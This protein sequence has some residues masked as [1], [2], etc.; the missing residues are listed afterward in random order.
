VIDRSLSPPKRPRL[1]GYDYSHPGAYFVTLC[2]HEKAHLFGDIV[3]GE[4]RLNR[5]GEIVRIEW[6]RSPELRPELEFGVFVIMPNHVH[7]IVH[8]RPTVENDEMTRFLAM[9]DSGLGIEE[10][11]CRAQLPARYRACAGRKPRSLGSF[12]AGFKA[13]STKRI[14][15]L[16]GTTGVR[17][18]QPDYFES[19]LFS[20]RARLNAQNYILENVS[21]WEFDKEN[22]LRSL[23]RT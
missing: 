14:N 11:H 4:M 15:E 9:R 2:A 19:I 12:I 16:R 20:A 6:V 18:W 17:V 5:I 23:M 8:I 22:P 21:R 13:H 7:A 1:K 3:N 10:S